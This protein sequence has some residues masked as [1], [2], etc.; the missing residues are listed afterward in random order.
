VTSGHVQGGRRGLEGTV[1][2]ACFASS[3]GRMW[4]PSGKGWRVFQGQ[5]A[6]A[7]LTIT[8]SFFSSS[9]SFFLLFIFGC[10][11]V[12]EDLVL[13]LGFWFSSPGASTSFSFPGSIIWSLGI[14]GSAQPVERKQKRVKGVGEWVGGGVEELGVV[15]VR[16]VWWKEQ[17][18]AKEWEGREGYL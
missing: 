6:L 1:L 2:E 11:F 14:A 13:G 16:P 18:S 17:R 7:I 15:V 3:P 8:T 9:K 5:F 4:K 10:L 12:V